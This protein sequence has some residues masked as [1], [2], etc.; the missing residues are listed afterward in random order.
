[1]E[2]RKAKIDAVNKS[3]Q[4]FAEKF[5]GTYQEEYNGTLQVENKTKE[6]L[7]NLGLSML[8]LIC[9]LLDCNPYTVTDQHNQPPY[10]STGMCTQPSSQ[11]LLC[12]RWLDMVPQRALSSIP[13]KTAQATFVTY[14][15]LNPCNPTGL[16]AHITVL[17][18]SKI[19]QYLKYLHEKVSTKIPGPCI[20]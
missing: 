11:A 5:S 19:K 3:L 4:S 14:M 18:P 16:M 6:L 13:T 20:N 17:C 9:R 12:W 1:M 10:L 15:C 8:N 2:I 7:K